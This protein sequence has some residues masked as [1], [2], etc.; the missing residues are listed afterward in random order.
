[1][2]WLIA[3]V[4]A[5]LTLSSVWLGSAA[6]AVSGLAAAARGGDGAGVLARSDLS[7]LKR[8]LS[9]QIVA[10]YLARAGETRAVRPAERV[11]AQ[12]YGSSIADALVGKLLTA[13]NLTVMLRTGMIAQG[14]GPA[15]AGMPS[16]SGVS[17]DYVSNFG[18]F[19][20]ISP[21]TLAIRVSDAS[22]PDDLAEI[23]MH[24]IWLDWRL[25]GVNVPRAKLREL[26]ARLPVR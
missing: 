19:R 5:L 17:T 1:M 21:S 13:E 18:R 10:A 6:V 22:T 23:E 25:S 24:R 15:I 11:L 3:L 16:L 4:A 8:S 7:A 20:F 2:R 9:E 14:D 26:V 12:T